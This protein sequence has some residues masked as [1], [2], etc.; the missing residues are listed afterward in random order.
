MRIAVIGA[1]PAGLT[2]ALELAKGGASV[3]VYEAGPQVGGL[4]RSLD[5]WGQRVDLGPHRFFSTDSRVNRFWLDVVGSDYVLVE[6]LTRIHFKRKFFHY[7]LKPFDVF[8][9]LGIVE[10]S[11]TL[12]SYL[13]QFFKQVSNE[14]DEPSFEAWIVRRFGRRLYETFFKTYSEKLW[15]IPCTELSEDFAAQRIRKLTLRDAVSNAMFRRTKTEHRTLA[16]CFAYPLGGT[17]AVYERIASQI[18]A[19]G[20]QILL[21][22]PVLNILTAA[23]R[24]TGV[25]STDGVEVPYD[26]VISTM[27]LTL[28][29]NGLKCA[30]QSV[31]YAATQLS[32]RNTVLVYLEVED[33]DLFRDQWLYVHDSDV[34]IGRVTNFRNWGTQPNSSTSIL[35]CELW[36]NHAD[37]TWSA[38]DRDLSNQVISELRQIGLIE[39]QPIRNSHVVRIPRSYPVYRIGY[40]QQVDTISNFLQS[41]EGLSVIGRYGAFKYNNQDHSL[42]MGLLAAENVLHSRHHNLWDLN[43]DFE[44]YQE[45]SLITNSGLVTTQ[46]SDILELRHQ[47]V[48]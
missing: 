21:R 8:T 13:K 20:G 33:P 10:T 45:Q 24:V 32:F 39:S 38:S 26:H 44:S 1:G 7:P 22:Q 46:T 37:S 28:L 34:Q 43:S 5:L 25:Q 30:P 29:V 18:V 17:G 41:I 9:K 3:D 48:C 40:Q 36:C 2:A 15:G 31:R 14:L 12:I 42:L 19:A 27:P 47:G 16:D 35:C 4:A 23:N 11:K 6:R